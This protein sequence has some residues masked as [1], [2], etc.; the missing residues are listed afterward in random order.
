MPLPMATRTPD[1]DLS[2]ELLSEF[3]GN[4]SYVADLLNRYR[5]NPGSV[6]DEWRRYFRERFGEPE[7]APAPAP[8]PRPVP[9]AASPAAATTEAPAIQGE[10]QPIRGAAARIAQNMEASL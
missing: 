3:G 2:D 10:R 6:D 9:P 8:A 1:V 4:A 7:P 5:T